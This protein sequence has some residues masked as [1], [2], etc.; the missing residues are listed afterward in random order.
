MLAATE[1]WYGDPKKQHTHYAYALDAARKRE[2]GAEEQLMELLDRKDLPAIVRATAIDHLAEFD[3]PTSRAAVIGQI[4][5]PEPLV[6]GVSIRHLHQ[7]GYPAKDLF[8]AIGPALS[9]PVRMVRTAATGVL[10]PHREQMS[11]EMRR[12]VDAAAA[13]FVSGQQADDDLAG[14][15]YNLAN[16]ALDSE[17]TGL[18]EAEY[19][20]ALAIDPQ[21]FP[22]RFNLGMLY[23][24][25]GEDAKAEAAFRALIAQDPAAALPR[26]RLGLI[27]G[28]MKKFTQA[29]QS[30][31]EAIE[32]EPKN[33]D[34]LYALAI[35]YLE[36]GQLEKSLLQARRLE[37]LM[38][39]VPRTRQ[40][41]RT[42]QQ[43]MQAAESRKKEKSNV[44]LP[45]DRIDGE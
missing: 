4:E 30:L 21:F 6:R 24:R 18:A 42:I 10:A 15:H 39:G 25:T 7:R 8:Q 29:E 45:R 37:A 13:E 14:S 31:G 19:L 22:A 5:H 11:P 9:D 28:R 23:S 38:P 34:Y 27:L 32:R 26:Y 16:F 44:N 36:S 33:F 43:K 41:I 1:K 12:R 3:T 35:L 40:L 20:Q 2:E 17:K